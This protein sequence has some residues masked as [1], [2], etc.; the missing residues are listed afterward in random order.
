MK[1]LPHITE[2]SLALAQQNVYSLKVS[3]GLNGPELKKQLKQ[4]FGVDVINSWSLKRKGKTTNFRQ[5]G[6]QRSS[7]KIIRVKLAKGQKI[8]GFELSEPETKK[9]QKV[10]S[11]TE[12]KE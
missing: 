8:D 7:Y 10:K 6:G 11:Q 4:H 3:D 1:I 5:R 2:K 12:T 9:D